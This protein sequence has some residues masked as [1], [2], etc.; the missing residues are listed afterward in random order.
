MTNTEEALWEV[1]EAAR[2]LRDALWDHMTWIL[3]ANAEEIGR[4]A[5]LVQSLK[6]LD[7]SQ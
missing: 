6:K 2:E 3:Y 1:A 5:Q 4:L 7:R